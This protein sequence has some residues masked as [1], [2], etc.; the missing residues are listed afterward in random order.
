MG[1]WV[2]EPSN[3]HA[4]ENYSAMKRNKLIYTHTLDES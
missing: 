3:T 4:V 2:N 1:E